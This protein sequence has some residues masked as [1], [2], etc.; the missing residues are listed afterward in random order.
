VK[1]F[2]VLN[3]PSMSPPSSE[4]S[5]RNKPVIFAAIASVKPIAKNELNMRYYKQLGPIEVVDVNSIQCV[6]GRVFD[7]GVWALI[8][9]NGIVQ[10]SGAGV[11]D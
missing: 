4:G 9:R 11:D 5:Q 6:V 10:T 7:R 8:E 3:L 2:F 1:S